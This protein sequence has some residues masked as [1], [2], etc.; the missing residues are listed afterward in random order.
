MNLFLREKFLIM[1]IF[2]E[3]VKKSEIITVLVIFVG[4]V[5]MKNKSIIIRTIPSFSAFFD[6]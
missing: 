6:D 1:D 4:L 5:S 2:I 3:F